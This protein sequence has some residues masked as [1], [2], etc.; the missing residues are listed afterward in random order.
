MEDNKKNLKDAISKIIK[1]A[2][3]GEFGLEGISPRTGNFIDDAYIANNLQERALGELMLEQY[4]GKVPGKKTSLN[5]LRDFAEGLREQFS[6]DVKSLIQIQ[7]E[8]DTMGSFTPSKDLIELKARQSPQDFASTLAHEALHSRDLRNK[9]YGDLV[10]VEPGQRTNKALRA[11]EGASDLVDET[12]KVLDPKKMREL[13][14][15]ADINDIKEALLKG[16]HGL[17]R[18]ATIAQANL[19]RILKGLPLKSIVGVLGGAA[20]LAAEAADSEEEGSASEQAA[21]LREIDAQKQM[22]KIEESTSVPNEVKLKALEL[23][24]KNKLPF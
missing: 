17:K 16:H 5:E 10:S 6:P 21:L 4:K 13:V 15:S 12:G 14:S 8:Y 3:S 7:P 23:F 1:N 18:G 2:Q 24:K 11:L 20:S 19:P 22:K 9:D